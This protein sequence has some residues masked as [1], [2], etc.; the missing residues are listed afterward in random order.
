MKLLPPGAIASKKAACTQPP[1]VMSNRKKGAPPCSHEELDESQILIKG[2]QI[3]DRNRR[4]IHIV[5]GVHSRVDRC[6]RLSG[7]KT[8]SRVGSG[9]VDEIHKIGNVGER[10]AARIAWHPVRASISSRAALRSSLRARTAQPGVRGVEGPQSY[11][12][13]PDQP[14]SR[15]P[16]V[17]GGIGP[18][19]FRGSGVATGWWHQLAI[20]S[21]AK[22]G[23]PI[24]LPSSG[25][26]CRVRAAPTRCRRGGR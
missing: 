19:R 10:A 9:T 17:Y 24:R 5:P 14:G 15:P 2:T 7:S 8:S 6:C 1:C 13:L 12:W 3:S 16:D 25:T 18:A 21:H 11:W 26:A 23:E 4:A 22:R 20:A